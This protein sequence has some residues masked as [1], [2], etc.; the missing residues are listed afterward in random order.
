MFVFFSGPAPLLPKPP[1]MQAY[2]LIPIQNGLPVQLPGQTMVLPSWP[3]NLPAATIPTASSLQ[4]MKQG[5]SVF[6]LHF[7]STFFQFNLQKLNGEKGLCEHL[8]SL[9]LQVLTL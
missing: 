6:D 2:A 5:I 7:L 1:P 3:A 4:L 9:E 8:F